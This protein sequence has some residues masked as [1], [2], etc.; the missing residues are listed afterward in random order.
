MY[1]VYKIS[2]QYLPA[3]VWRMIKKAIKLM[4]II[5]VLFTIYII[6]QDQLS[7]NVILICAIGILPAYALALLIAYPLLKTVYR[8]FRIIVDDDGV[9]FYISGNDKKISWNNLQTVKQPN[10]T[11]ELH[12]KHVS[13]FFRKLTGEGNIQ[14]I[15]EI[16][17]FDELLTEIDKYKGIQK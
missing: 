4:V 1:Q 15:P 7:L 14:L 3:A 8:T 16:E 2:E 12:D 11:M 9:E 10:G 5:Y 13:T 6:W 17:R